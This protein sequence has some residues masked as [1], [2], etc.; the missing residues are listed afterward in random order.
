MHLIPSMIFLT[1]V[2]PKY[3]VG[4]L[5]EPGLSEYRVFNRVTGI[6]A[7]DLHTDEGKLNSK[8]E[9]VVSLFKEK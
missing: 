4:L 2:V 6:L 5:I 9:T 1:F 8:V 7:S 3:V